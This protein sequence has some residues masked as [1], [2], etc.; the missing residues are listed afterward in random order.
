MSRTINIISL[1]KEFFFLVIKKDLSLLDNNRIDQIYNSL[2]SLG[3]VYIK[4][5]QLLAQKTDLFTNFEYLKEKLSSLQSSNRF[6]SLEDTEI[7]FNKNFK[8]SINSFF[9]KYEKKALH[10]GTI[11][12]TYFVQFPGDNNNYIMKIKHPNIKNEINKDIQEFKIII[13]ILKRNFYSCLNSIDIEEFFI[14]LKK[15]T[16]FLNEVT[17][18]NSIHQSIKVCKQSTSALK[19]PFIKAYSPDIIIQEWCSGDHYNQF[20]DKYPQ[21]RLKSKIIAAKSF[22]ELLYI[23]KILHMDCHNGNIIYSINEEGKII[24]SFVDFGLANFVSLQDLDIISNFIKAINEKSSILLF[25]TIYL[26]CNASNNTNIK[27]ASLFNEEEV[28]KFFDLK[29]NK[30]AFTFIKDTLNKLNNKGIKINNN[31]L[32]ILINLSLIL[33]SVDQDYS[34]EI[35]IFDLVIHEIIK[36]NN[37]LYQEYFKYIIDNHKFK[38]KQREIFELYKNIDS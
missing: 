28:I 18:N 9:S 26:C 22:L 10:S 21:Y 27:I 33:E 8:C 5:G 12:Q 37:I 24:T 2:L 16:D 17:Y 15:Q 25:S 34:L 32:Y 29:K 30:E 3:P 36:D 19:V 23:H 7:I 38:N 1:F 35:S 20:I 11:S 4:F 14:Y 6:H 13:S 31:I